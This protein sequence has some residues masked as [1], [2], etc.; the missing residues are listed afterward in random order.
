MSLVINSLG[1]ETHTHK[2]AYRRFAQDQ[3]TRCTPACSQRAPGLIILSYLLVFVQL[4][5]QVDN[6]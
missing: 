4:T 6:G 1:A 2:H 5:W 3:E